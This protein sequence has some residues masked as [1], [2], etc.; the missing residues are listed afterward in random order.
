M[1]LLRH[2]SCDTKFIPLKI[3]LS[4]INSVRCTSIT[5]ANFRTFH[6]ARS[7]SILIIN[8]SS[9]FCLYLLI[10]NWLLTSV[11]SPILYMPHKCTSQI[12]PLCFV[13]K[14]KCVMWSPLSI[15]CSLFMLV[16]GIFPSCNLWKIIFASIQSIPF[17]SSL[18]NS[19]VWIFSN[20]SFG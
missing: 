14:S 19:Y 20:F 9:H 3:Q 13:D 16:K 11:I 6:H 17:I 2:N 15:S 12:W 4:V 8:E 10:N 18:R 1:Y 5:L 7:D